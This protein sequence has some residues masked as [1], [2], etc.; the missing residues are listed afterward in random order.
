MRSL[1]SGGL[2][3]Y[4]KVSSESDV[5]ASSTALA[6]LASKTSALEDALPELT[7]IC[8]LF[9]FFFSFL[10]LMVS[11][12]GLAL[13]ACPSDDF[14]PDASTTC[15]M[16]ATVSVSTVMFCEE[17]SGFALNCFEE[18]ALDCRWTIGGGP[19][20]VRRS[21][22]GV[23]LLVS[24]AVSV[25]ESITLAFA[26]RVGGSLGTPSDWP[27]SRSPTRAMSAASLD[28][29]GEF[30]RL[31]SCT[32]SRALRAGVLVPEGTAESSVSLPEVVSKGSG[33]ESAG[34]SDGEALG[35]LTA[36]SA[37]C[38][39]QRPAAPA[40]LFSGGGDL[41]RGETGHLGLSLDSDATGFRGVGA[42]IG[43][44]ELGGSEGVEVE[45]RLLEDA[46]RIGAL[47]RICIWRVGLIS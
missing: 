40:A 8:F 10:G 15:G 32:V 47:A 41:R 11:V 24:L 12:L 13:S 38:S 28:G 39:F 30:G 6:I 46:V 26:W 36:G 27:P 22:F 21:A 37:S 43:G 4:T 45:V 17:L 20:L 33:A 34:F 9:G 1:A 23:L 7:L 16:L 35:T 18:T 3:S 19:E 29:L 44:S 25:S 5:L 14:G 2:E 31:T 42:W